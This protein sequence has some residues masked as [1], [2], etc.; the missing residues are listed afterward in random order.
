MTEGLGYTITL[1]CMV[2]VAVIAGILAMAVFATDRA[3]MPAAIAVFCIL[4]L[5]LFGGSK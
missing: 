4:G 3:A 1:I 5:V 2:A